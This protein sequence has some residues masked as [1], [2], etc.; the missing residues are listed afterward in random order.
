MGT[1][2]TFQLGLQKSVYFCQVEIN[3]GVISRRVSQKWAFRNLGEAASIL[4]QVPLIITLNRAKVFFTKIQCFISEHENPTNLITALFTESSI[5]WPWS[6]HPSQN[7][8]DS[9]IVLALSPAA[10]LSLLTECF[11]YS[12]LGPV[13]LR[14]I[15]SSSHRVL[16]IPHIMFYNR[17]FRLLL[18]ASCQV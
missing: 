14:E 7:V 3:Y 16:L 6:L 11:Q 1:K 8:Q 13:L 12:P 17:L 9:F 5:P 4:V 2:R 10:C 15:L 18:G